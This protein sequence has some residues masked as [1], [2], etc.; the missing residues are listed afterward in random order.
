MNKKIIIWSVIGVVALFVLIVV[1]MGVSY[2]NGEK[3]LRNKVEAEKVIYESSWDKLFKVI[4]QVAQVPEAAKE[5]F[6]DMY[7]PLMEGR[8]SNERG[9]A[10]WSFIQEH[11]PQFDWGLYENV[12]K[13]VETHREQFFQDGRKLKAMQV[14]HQNMLATWPSSMFVGDR[15]AIEVTIVTSTMAKQVIESGVDDNIEL[16]PK[17]EGK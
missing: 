1:I 13:A 12:Q 3:K 10:M 11:N 7:I 15:P 9:G 8:Y 17:K 4:S 6:K 16:F 5:A 14:E 2:S